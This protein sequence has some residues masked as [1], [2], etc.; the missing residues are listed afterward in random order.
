VAFQRFFD[1]LEPV[2]SH[3]ISLGNRTRRDLPGLHDAP[4]LDATALESGIHPTTIRLAV[5]DE[6]PKDLIAHFVDAAR[7]AID[8]VIPGFSNQFSSGREIDALVRKTYL[9]AHQRHIDAKRPF[10]GYR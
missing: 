1:S 2:F 6:D 4:E 10:D 8:P 5:G 7:L 3:M 9:E